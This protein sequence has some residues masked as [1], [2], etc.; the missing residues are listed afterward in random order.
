MGTWGDLPAQLRL[1]VLEIV[2]REHSEWS[3]PHARV[4]YAVV[5]KEWQLF[6]EEQTFR[7]LILNQY[8]VA[9]LERIVGSE[10]TRRTGY[11]KYVCLCVELAEYDCSVCHA[12]EDT[13]TLRKFVKS[14]SPSLP[15]TLKVYNL[16]IFRTPAL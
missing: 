5:C 4:G 10:K 16:R 3:E 9:D 8:R 11:L 14:P 15:N 7:R 1:M 2:S 12:M 6:W 13:D